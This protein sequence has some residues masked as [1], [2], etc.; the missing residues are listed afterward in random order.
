M[1]ILIVYYS[2][3][4][5]TKSAA[6]LLSSE[7]KSLAG[8]SAV[9]ETEEIIDLKDRSG[10][11]GWIGAGR[12]ATFNREA[13]IRPLKAKVEDFDLVVVGTPVWA[14]TAAP[15]VR[16]FCERY[17]RGAK[18][19]GFLCTMGGSG[20]RGAFEAMEKACGKKPRACLPLVIKPGRSESM[21]ALRPKVRRFAEQLLRVFPANVG[22]EAR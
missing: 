13:Q 15:A 20:D 8:D 4:G 9:V 19:V 18:A 3:T 14:F 17:G 5:V 6:A 22:G 10:I 1:K 16:T 21:E 12:D 2:R 7:I 11:L